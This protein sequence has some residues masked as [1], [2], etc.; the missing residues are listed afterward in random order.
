MISTPPFKNSNNL[1]EA[2]VN[3]IA[4]FD[5]FDF[6]L[7]A[8]EVWQYIPIKCDFADVFEL[9]SNGNIPDTVVG[10]KDGYY[11]LTGRENTI[12]I[13]LDR[14]NFSDRKFKRALRYTRVFK[15][16]PWIKLVAIGNQIGINNLKDQSDI[17]FFIITERGR[18]WL[19]RLVIATLAAILR[20]RPQPGREKDSICLSFYVSED[21]LPLELMQLSGNDIYFTYWLACLTPIYDLGGMYK[22]FIKEN[23]W[24]EHVLPN[25]TGV[26]TVERRIVKKQSNKLYKEICDL[27]IGGLEENCRKMQLRLLPDY[28]KNL[29]NQGTEVIM[30]RS[31]LKLHANDRRAS[32]RKRWE[33]KVNELRL[34]LP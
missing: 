21:G 22:K 12:T 24:L 23:F 30:S 13:R 7:T 19:T 25:W 11:F 33:D 20:L 29:L 8:M 4:F 18:L 34:R 17:D 6:P 9:L 28:L 10:E 27:L 15:F 3:T 14:Y 1:K 2:I 31:V 26:N 16:I 5:L 32:Y